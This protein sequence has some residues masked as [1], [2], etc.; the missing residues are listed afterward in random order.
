VSAS[1][2]RGGQ[3]Y[4]EIGADTKKVF[5][6]IASVN[7][8]LSKLGSFGVGAG[9]SGMA[10]GMANVLKQAR[11]VSKAISAAGV[12]AQGLGTKMS[13]AGLAVA[14][15]VGLALRQFA[16]FDDAIRATAAV[17]GSLGA[18]GAAAFQSLN[19]KA[20]D[21]GAT[22]S[23]T[24][25][26]VANLMT[27]LGRAG[28]KPD[29]INAMTGAVLDMSRATGTDATRSAGI[30]AASLRQF[31]LGAGDAARA[32]DILT[33]TANNTF[34]TVDGLGESLKY[35]GPVAKSLGMSLEDTTA[36]LGV[37]GNVGIQGSEAGTALRRLSVIS[38]GAGAK[39]QDLFGVSNVDAAGNL[40]PLVQILDEIN[41]ATM[42][43]PVAERTAKMAKAFGLL[44]ITSANVLS[45]SAG[46][47][48]K[49]AE[50]LK[51]AD[52]TAMR[53]AKAMD[54]GLGGAMRIA[55]SAIE[56]TQLAI[57]DAL[58]PTLQTVIN[59]IEDLATGV[60]AFVKQ[61]E[62]VVVSVMKGTAAVIGAGVAFYA[63]GT[64]I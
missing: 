22:T 15:P 56:G 57:G 53:T 30:M 17:T 49:L 54:A 6:A 40:K 32:A 39:L 58:A 60:T 27:E 42:G 7:Q 28:F 18:D 11:N 19:D 21:L 62:G 43:M 41:T 45:Q 52:G 46:G 59:F 29:E 13:V 16:T 2:V 14:A 31:E 33:Y 4:V 50:G 64:A 3:V 25:V 20:R 63:L 35:A 36:I 8:R 48:Q 51:T 61:N 37:L 34:N 38:S 1:A 26:E 24:A 9:I 5:A 10:S 44:G 12:A 23:L 47:V 55:L